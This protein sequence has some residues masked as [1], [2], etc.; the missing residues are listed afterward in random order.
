MS[1]FRVHKTSG[2]T[3]MSNGHLRD[4][5]LSLKAKGLLSLI[6]SLPDDWVHSVKGYV[7]FCADGERSVTSAL[8]ELKEFG[9]VTVEK[10]N[11]KPG[12]NKFT[13]IYNI[14]EKP[15]V[16]QGVRFVPLQ[17]VGLHGVG[18]QTVPLLNTENKRDT[19]EEELRVRSDSQVDSSSEVDFQVSGNPDFVPPTIEEIKDY[20]KA[21]MFDKV[22]PVLFFATY[23]AQGWVTSNNVPITNWQSLLLK[24]QVR[25]RSVLQTIRLQKKLEKPDYSEFSE[26]KW[27]RE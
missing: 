23:D 3:V 8:K 21:N 20:C 5:N 2:F 14:Y 12:S 13:Y 7:S 15:Q 6:L 1:V 26:D 18:L 4:S 16:S 10:V 24:W 9:Y 22:D 25:D 11:P 19:S 27:E 17:D